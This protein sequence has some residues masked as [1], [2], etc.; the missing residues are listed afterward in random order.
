MNAIV[1]D[2]TEGEEKLEVVNRIPK[3]VG[4]GEESRNA[5]A[6]DAS[7]GKQKVVL[8]NEVGAK[9]NTVTLDNTENAQALELANVASGS[10]GNRV[11]MGFGGDYPVDGIELTDSVGNRIALTKDSS[12]AAQ[13]QIQLEGSEAD[14]IAIQAATGE[15]PTVVIKGSTPVHIV[16]SK[17]LLGDAAAK[18][19]LALAPGVQK[20]LENLEN[21]FNQHMHTGNM[22]GPTP[23]NPANMIIPAT[24]EEQISAKNVFASP[25][26]G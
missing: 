1:L 18:D 19:A 11:K 26:M 7:G 22:G 17:V 5:L 3:A 15:S 6:L 4:E 9:T 16:G 23:L 20:R 21:T 8:A 2:R 13:I 12:G 24:L 25:T 14:T 10:T